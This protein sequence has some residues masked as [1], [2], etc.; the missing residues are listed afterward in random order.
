[1]TR[2]SVYFRVFAALVHVLVLQSA[3]AGLVPATDVNP[4]PD[5]FECY[6]TADE[7]DVTIGGATVHALVYKDDPPA[8]FAPATPGIPAL[9]PTASA[10]HHRSPKTSSP[11]T[12]A[13]SSTTRASS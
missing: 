11:S 6:L 10:G 13:T 9:I 3:R 2:R 12:S 8:P 7:Q 1:M 4:D 5:V